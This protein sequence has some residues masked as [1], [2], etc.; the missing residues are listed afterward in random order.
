MEWIKR[1]EDN[2]E[3]CPSCGATRLKFG[4]TAGP[5]TVLS[6]PWCQ[7]RWRYGSRLI[8][9]N[10]RHRQLMAE[11]MCHTRRCSEWHSWV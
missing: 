10:T 5:R 9:L 2:P 6:C 3:Q 4:R 11:L 7:L 1:D 8:R